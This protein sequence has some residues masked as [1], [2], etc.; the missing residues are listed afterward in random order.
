MREFLLSLP[1]VLELQSP[2][3]AVYVHAGDQPQAFYTLSHLSGPSF[4]LLSLTTL[5]YLITESHRLF[6]G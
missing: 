6:L 3:Q 2:H 4:L 1:P 5:Q